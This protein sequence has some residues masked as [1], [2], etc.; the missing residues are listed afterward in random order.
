M[1]LSDYL[2]KDNEGGKKSGGGRQR[3]KEYVIE[4]QEQGKEPLSFEEWN[5]LQNG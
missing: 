5:R 2:P 1:N 4:A 3:Y